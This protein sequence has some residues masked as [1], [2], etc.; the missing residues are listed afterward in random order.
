MDDEIGVAADGRREMR[1]APKIEA[2]MPVILVGV[3]SLR[4]RAQHD[5]VD[6][7]LGWIALHASQNSVELRR[8]NTLALL[9]FTPMPA[10]N[11]LKSRSFS[12]VGASWAR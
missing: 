4:L 12:K 8:A 3:F 6:Q 10:R 5:F 2:E 1:V 11:S 7:S 9:N